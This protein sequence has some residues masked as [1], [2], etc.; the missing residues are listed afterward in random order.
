MHTCIR[1]PLLHQYPT[2]LQK[3]NASFKF[4][5]RIFVDRAWFR[6]LKR[7][8]RVNWARMPVL[9][10]WKL[11]GRIS[12][13]WVTCG[14][15]RIESSILLLW[16]HRFLKHRRKLSVVWA[17]FQISPHKYAVKSALHYTHSSRTIPKLQPSANSLSYVNT[18][19]I[20][21][22]PSCRSLIW[23]VIKSSKTNLTKTKPPPQ[24]A[25][26]HMSH[27]TPPGCNSVLHK[28]PF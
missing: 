6:W 15:H 9:L 23:L 21:S 25:L 19:V 7:F 12:N 13:F 4:W 26:A 1:W 20:V 3:L 2:Q 16:L 18:K 5:R 11:P 24:S 10:S 27:C 22:G 17:S 28:L 14:A 8:W